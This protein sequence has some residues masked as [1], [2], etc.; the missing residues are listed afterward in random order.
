LFSS[1]NF[2]FVDI[3]FLNLEFKNKVFLLKRQL[4]L[5]VPSL[6]IISVVAIPLVLFTL[7]RVNNSFKWHYYFEPGIFTASEKVTISGETYTLETYMWRD[8]QP[9]SPPNGKPLIAII[10]VHAVGIVSFPISTIIERLWLMDDLIIVSTGP[11]EEYMMDGNTLEMVFRNGPKWEPG[12]SIDV[13]VK[14][15]SGGSGT[16]YLKAVNQKIHRTD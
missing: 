8:F 13:V 7:D 10:R 3:L 11:T 14:L 4:S 12:I 9:I 2:K 16:Y 1:K 15:I 5:I 6:L